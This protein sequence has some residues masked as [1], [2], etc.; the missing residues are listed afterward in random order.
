[1]FASLK[2]DHVAK[3]VFVYFRV[4]Q[5]LGLPPPEKDLSNAGSCVAKSEASG[6]SRLCAMGQ[7]LESS[8]FYGPPG[9][10]SVF[11]LPLD[12]LSNSCEGVGLHRNSY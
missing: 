3:A 12:V 11:P 2:D 10:S 7:R 1:M 6:L 4:E 8:I 9:A 5:P